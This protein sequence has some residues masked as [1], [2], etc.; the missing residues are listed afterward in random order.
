MSVTPTDDA[1]IV[2][3]D[4]EGELRDAYRGWLGTF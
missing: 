4:F 3:L 1:L 2:T